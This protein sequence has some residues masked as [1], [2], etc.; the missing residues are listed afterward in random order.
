MSPGTPTGL[1]D[2]TTKFVDNNDTYGQGG[3][4]VLADS[5][6]T[7]TLDVTGV[8]FDNIETDAV[9]V[10]SRAASSFVDVNLINNISING[11]G[12]DNVPAGGGFA[13]V[14]DKGGDYNFDILNNNLRDISG[15]GIVIVAEGTVQGRI[16]NN[17]VSGTVV[18]DGIRVDTEQRDGP[19]AGNNYAVTIEVRGNQIGVDPTFPGIGDDGIQVLHRDGTKTLNLTIENN[20]VGNTSVANV[21]EG[22]RYFQDADVSDGQGLNYANVR[23]AGNTFSSI[24]TSDALVF[25]LQ[26]TVDADL[27]VSGNLFVGPNHNISLSQ[28]GTSVLQISQATVTA[29]AGANINATASVALG[30]ISILSPAGPPLLPSNP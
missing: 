18:G 9:M 28:A 26:E 13:I 23:V 20:L 12:P 27:N 11:G 19:A 15:D 30:T 4:L 5:T 1:T 10:Q 25:I 21:G 6:A 2:S 29:L 7:I 8:M 16:D 22:I 24:G 17:V 14:S 3:I